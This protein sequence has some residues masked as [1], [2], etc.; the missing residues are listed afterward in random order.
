MI[1]F[2]LR[3]QHDNLGNADHLL[4]DEDRQKIEDGTWYRASGDCVCDACGKTYYDHPPVIGA[5][6]LTR[7]CDGDL[8]HL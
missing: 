1:P 2:D 6:S 5:L 8:V 7:L 3:V 4:A